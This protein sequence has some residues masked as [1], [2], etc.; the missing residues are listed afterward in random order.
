[1][2]T[3]VTGAVT[4]VQEYKQYTPEDAQVWKRL[5][6]RQMEI[7]PSIANSE[8]LE[9]VQTMGFNA[10]EIPNFKKINTRLGSLTGWNVVPVNGII[11]PIDF[12]PLLAHKKFPSTTWLRPMHQLDFLPEPDMFH[13][14]MGHLPLLSN[15][16]FA[17]F[18]Q[19]I[20]VLGCQYQHV[21]K[22]T[23]MLGCLYWYAVEFGL[24]QVEND[25]VKVYGAGI[26]SS[27]GELQSALNKESVY[28]HFDVQRILNSSYDDSHIQQQYFVIESFEQL[29]NSMDEVEQLLIHV[30]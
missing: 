18:F 29:Y 6:N 21:P 15:Q 2:N 24:I 4:T 1:M 30:K 25:T 20:G 13:D 26:L 14:V 27:Y 5:F 11:A 7:L 9:G 22:A 8:Y 10:E 19:R 17:D 23:A 28:L 3:Y 12:F 16:V